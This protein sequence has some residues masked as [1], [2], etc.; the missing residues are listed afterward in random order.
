MSRFAVVVFIVLAV[1]FAYRSFGSAE[2]G[3]GSLTLAQPAPTVND[4][5]P[6]FTARSLNRE[7]FRLHR[8]GIYVLSFW[9]TLNEGSANAR[10][11]LSRLARDYEDSKVTFVSVY[12]NDAPDDAREI[13]YTVIEDSSGILASKYNVKRVPRLFLIRNGEVVLVQNGYFEGNE[14]QLD[15]ELEKTLEEKNASPARVHP[16]SHDRNV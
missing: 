1:A 7:T 13:P 3:T 2:T 16:R 10:P 4:K 9:S 6:S 12:V 11:E 15:N 8:K 14:K 5:A